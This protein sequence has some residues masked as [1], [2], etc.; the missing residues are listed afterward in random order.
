[1]ANI[2][3]SASKKKLRFSTSKGQLAIEDLWTLSLISL[4]TIAIA[5]NKKLKEE[6]EE[7][8]LDETPRG[9]YDDRLRLDIL[10]YIIETKKDEEKKRAERITKDAQI[11]SLKSLIETKESERMGSLSLEDLQKQLA[12]LTTEA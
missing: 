4:N 5:V 7:S 10:K 8:F 3:E 9:S 12:A 2:F 1:M 6:Q 11:A